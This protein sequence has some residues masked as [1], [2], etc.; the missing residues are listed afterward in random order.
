MSTHHPSL[1][2]THPSSTRRRYTE[3]DD[4][5]VKGMVARHPILPVVSFATPCVNPLFL[6]LVMPA[7]T[8]EMTVVSIPILLCFVG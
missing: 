4:E 6:S 2:N 8:L 1:L 3:P 7:L 5:L